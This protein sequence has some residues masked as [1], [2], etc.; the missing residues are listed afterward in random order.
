MTFASRYATVKD[1]MNYTIKQIEHRCV[2]AGLVSPY[3]FWA[4]GFW[5]VSL[6]RL[7]DRKGKGAKCPYCKKKLAN[8]TIFNSLSTASGEVWNHTL[9]MWIKV[10]LIYIS[11][12]DRRKKQ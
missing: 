8:P 6:E 7:G 2:D 11:K 3:P 5:F 9:K 12:R 10:P 1:K 4:A